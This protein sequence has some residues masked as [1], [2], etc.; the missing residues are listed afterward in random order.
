M[1]VVYIDLTEFLNNPVLTG[2]QR[3][4]AEI[5]KWWPN[6]GLRP[7]CLAP[8]GELV[9]LPNRLIAAIV[10][11]FSSP[12][13]AAVEEVRKLRRETGTLIKPE[14]PE[15]ILVSELFYDPH[16]VAFFRK[17]S[18]R[19]LE[20][21]RFIVYDLMPLLHPE[22]FAPDMPLDIICGYFSMVRRIPHC[23][24]IS[25]WTQETYC[26]RLLRSDHTRGIV[27][28][29]GSDGLG[30][31]PKTTATI[32]PLHFC[33]VGTLEP[34]KNQAL[35]V[36]AF[37]PLLRN[38]EGLRLTLL[39]RLGWADKAFIDRVR[40][41]SEGNCPGFEWIPNPDDDCIRRHVEAARATVYVSAAEGFGLP[42]V[43]SLWLRTPVIASPDLP[44]LELIGSCGVE[45]VDPLNASSLREAV[46][47]FL[48]DSYASVKIDETGELD[49]PT[50]ASFANQVARWCK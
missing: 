39:G 18:E 17:M 32:R 9:E 2:I 46:L 43:E 11:C 34:R 20:R 12:D 8:S 47:K 16:R 42:P 33:S 37:E 10:R 38:T 48:D 22:Y 26:K 7:I 24:F 41:L 15:S 30:A 19:S 45:V 35:I 13:G 28:R 1:S 3:V 23:G 49:L 50:W 44:S 25:G 36:D 14:G 5:C 4:T 31:R 29:L 21:F 40:W 6:G 27:L